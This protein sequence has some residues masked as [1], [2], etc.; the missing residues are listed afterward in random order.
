MGSK[1]EKPAVVFDE[2]AINALA[3]PDPAAPASTKPNNDPWSTVQAAED[4]ENLD[5]LKVLL[6]GP[7]G[8]GKST[9][10][11]KFR[12]PLIGLTEKQALP[13]I[14][15]A[16]PR[17]LVKLIA[18]AQDLLEFMQ[19][20]RSETLASRCDAVVLDSLTDAQRMLRDFYTA[21]GDPQE[22]QYWS[23]TAPATARIA[24]VLRDLPV[25]VMVICMDA[26]T[27]VP[28]EGIVHRPALS[29]GKALNNLAQYFNVAG[30]I[31]YQERSGG[32]RREVMF[33]GPD[34][35]RVKGL[36]GINAVEAPEPLLW[37]NKRFGDAIPDDKDRNGLTVSDRI[38]QWESRGRPI[39]SATIE[40]T[41]T[42]TNTDGTA[43]PF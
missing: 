10:G 30:F 39:A 16:N 20:C 13:A 6:T 7:S 40:T 42:N 12:C 33:D 24:R 14:K 27:E 26:E 9:T 32:K 8:G 17:A 4:V 11:A 5:K 1:K 19:L 31:S 34:R 15:E 36:T 25:H 23:N 38:T 2:G 28:G 41:S 21:K 18:N 43:N 22:Q 35:Y 29:G 37:L 3:G